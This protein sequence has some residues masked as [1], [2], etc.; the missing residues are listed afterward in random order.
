MLNTVDQIGTLVQ[1]GF[2]KLA[3]KLNDH[4]VNAVHLFTRAE[5]KYM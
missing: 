3:V 4:S 5:S 1:Q 2:S